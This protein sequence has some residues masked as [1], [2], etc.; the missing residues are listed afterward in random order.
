MHSINS[1]ISVCVCVCVY[2]YAE[3]DVVNK[4]TLLFKELRKDELFLKR[5][6]LACLVLS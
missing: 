5:A 4:V 3:S 2:E 1:Y 6:L